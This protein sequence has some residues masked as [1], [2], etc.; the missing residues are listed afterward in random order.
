MENSHSEQL[1]RFGSTSHRGGVHTS[2]TMMLTE[3]I[4]L[5]SYFGSHDATKVE[6]KHAIVAENCLSKRSS[7]TRELT[8]RHLVSLY[9]LDSS[10]VIYRALLFFWNRDPLAQPLLA[11]LCGVT[12]DPILRC[13]TP[14][15]LNQQE[16]ERLPR[17]STEVYVD[18]LDPGRF[19]KA[20][21]TSTAQ[22]INSTWTQSGHLRGRSH[23]IRSRA[24]PT[25]AS[26]SY[27]LFLGYLSGVRGEFLFETLFAKLLD[28]PVGRMLELASEASRKGWIVFNSIENV[29]E[30]SFPKLI[31]SQEM[32]SLREQG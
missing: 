3:L 4:V 26:V 29:I 8:Y 27:A 6:Y 23:K 13:A 18:S 32:Q 15:I 12:R 1:I 19:S 2:R 28:C 21:L 24:N 20:T 9:S 14:L 17:E 7:K 25:A 30:V 22:N 16:G 5:L 31:G 10:V 11:L